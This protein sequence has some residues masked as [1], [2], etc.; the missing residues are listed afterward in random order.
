LTIIPILKQSPLLNDIN[1]IICDYCAVFKSER[2]TLPG[3]FY[4][5]EKV[6][7]QIQSIILGLGMDKILKWG[8][9]IKNIDDEEE[10]YYFWLDGVIL[11]METNVM[12]YD[13]QPMTSS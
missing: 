13:F 8:D 6:T 11:E 2:Y 10:F 1:R 9:N 5:L 4:K 7:Q 3:K 12:D